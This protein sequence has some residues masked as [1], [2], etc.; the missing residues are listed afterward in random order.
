MG[1]PNKSSSSKSQSGDPGVPPTGRQSIVNALT[2]EFDLPS[3]E[4]LPDSENPSVPAYISILKGLVEHMPAPVEISRSHAWDHVVKKAQDSYP[5][6]YPIQQ[7]FRL[8]TIAMRDIVLPQLIPRVCEQVQLLA[9]WDAQF[10]RHKKPAVIRSVAYTLLTDELK[11]T[12]SIPSNRTLTFLLFQHCATAKGLTSP[13]LIPYPNLRMH[14][15]TSGVMTSVVSVRLDRC[16]RLWALDAG[17]VKGGDAQERRG[18]T[19]V[20]VFDVETNR[21]LRS[22]FFELGDGFQ[23]PQV[24]TIVVDVTTADCNNAFAYD[25]TFI[26][27]R[28]S[29]SCRLR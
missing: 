4:D 15:L 5:I 23:E 29:Y 13:L 22:R 9:E 19:G 26:F 7:Q 17:T 1:T 25:F 6:Q 10:G 3:L 21:V 16:N 12:F 2:K 27:S 24:A 8:F 20:H 28:G 11:D 14:N 18:A